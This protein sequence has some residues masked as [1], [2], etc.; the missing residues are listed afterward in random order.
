MHIAQGLIRTINTNKLTDCGFKF[1]FWVADWFAM[2]NHKLGGD[3]KKIRKA[4][5]LMI[6]TWKA[7]GM[8]MEN[9]EFIW[10]SEEIN[11]QPDKY[12]SL[13]MDISTKFKTS[14]IQRC[15]QIMGRK[16]GEEL[17]CSQMLYPCMQC[18]I[19][20][21]GAVRCYEYTINKYPDDTYTQVVQKMR[22]HYNE[23]LSVIPAYLYYLLVPNK[24]QLIIETDNCIKWFENQKCFPSP[25]KIQLIF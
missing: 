24:E 10:S 21:I 11:R 14:R 20:K 2:L 8:N 6:E 7:C 15:T 18:A 3:L 13:V 5:E 23:K 25:E 1:K 16:E 19:G 4:G 9:V 17:A 12:L 22:Q